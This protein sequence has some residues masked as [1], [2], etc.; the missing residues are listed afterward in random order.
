MPPERE[1]RVE[2]GFAAKRTGSRFPVVT[3]GSM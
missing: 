1:R 2:E 3:D